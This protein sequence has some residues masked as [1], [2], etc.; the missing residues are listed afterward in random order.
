MSPFMRSRQPRGLGH[1]RGDGAAPQ[2]PVLI[3]QPVIV[4]GPRANPKWRSV[5]GSHPGL[6]RLGHR[7]I[8]RNRQDGAA[9]RGMDA[10]RSSD[11]T[12]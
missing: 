4:S 11:D 2:Q 8:G 1:P 6:Q 7:H 3:D 10:S 9:G 12:Q 5:Y